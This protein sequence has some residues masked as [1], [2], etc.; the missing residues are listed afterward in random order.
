MKP[1][2]NTS[3]LTYQ[4]EHLECENYVS[5]EQAIWG[6][7]ELESGKLFIKENLKRHTLVFVLEGEL[8]ISST[9]V[10][11]Q[12]IIAGKMFLIPAGGN[13]YGKAIRDTL[14][15][16]CSF[17]HNMALCNRFSIERL[18]I[19]ATEIHKNIAL[20]PIHPLLYKEL[21]TTRYI[22][23]TG[24]WC[25]H[26]QRIKLETLFIELRGF[27]QR[28]DLVALFAPILGKDSDFKDKVMSLYTEVNTAK[29]LAEKLNMSSTGFKRKFHKTFGISAKQWLIQKKKEK[30]LRDILMTNMPVAEL[31]EKYNFTVNYL[32][33]FCQKHFG[34]S[35][36]E[37]RAKSQT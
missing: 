2:Q 5:N 23:Q 11:E 10:I 32:A 26:Y 6:I 18:Q 3:G 9:Q 37:L 36:T 8:H 21:E 4:K 19:Y 16:R 1:M 25:I 27:Y 15:M 33:T 35:P 29:E 12:K 13:F 14:F 34:K 24:L 30:L 20:I 22:L 31:A 17:T 28:K 7:Q